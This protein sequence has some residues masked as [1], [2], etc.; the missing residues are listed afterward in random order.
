VTEVGY[1]GV[2]QSWRETPA[3][4]RVVLLGVFI[5]YFG[6]FLEAFLVLYLLDRGF[7]AQ[8]AGVAL[9]AYAVGTIVGVLFGGGLLND[10]LG[11]RWT[12][13]VSMGAS[14]LLTLSV[15][16]LD[17]FAAI[18]VAVTVSGALA[19]ASRPAVSALLLGLVPAARQV[20]TMAMY[21]TAFNTGLMIGPLVAAYLSTISWDLVLWLEAVT[22]LTY[23][24]IAAFVLPRNENTEQ[25]EK[26][27]P[28]ERVG[29][30]LVLRDTRYA[31]YLV[32]ML[33][34]GLVHVQAIAVLPL[35][36]H[37]AGY[38]T[39]A[40]STLAVVT[41][42]LLISTELFVTKTTQTWP[43]WVAV[44]GGWV[45]LVVG[46]GAWGLPGG[47]TVLV[48]AA[49]IGIAGQIIGGAQAFAYPAKVAPPGAVGRYIG[50]AHAMF[51]LG[52]AIGP[53]VGVLLWTQMGN[54]FWAFCPVFGLV[55][56]VLGLWGM[57]PATER[58]A[59]PV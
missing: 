7:S 48:A 35:M 46:R 21:R 36:L 37:Q 34:N 25:A 30:L 6:A 55:I 15:T 24:V 17:S 19:Q 23:V 16:A 27:P 59:T 4:V 45:L 54:A 2:A 3:A 26:P 53:P 8:Q 28:G 52:Y 38:A 56:G 22:A 40:Y 9:G 12:I 29:Y 10:R 41:T 11:P 20:M 31:A 14:A 44:L 43:A 1:A 42:G 50:S 5:T 32:L 13:M 18:V 33:A 47:F 39:W 49:V 57:H 51:A 58:R